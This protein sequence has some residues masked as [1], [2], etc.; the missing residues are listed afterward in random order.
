MIV[1]P[2]QNTEPV[3]E[4]KRAASIVKFVTTMQRESERETGP[5]R[6]RFELANK[7]FKG[8]QPWS[9]DR[10]NSQWMAQ[11]FVHEFSTIVRRCAAAAQDLVFQRPDFFS[12]V[13]LNE[14][15]M[16]GGELARISQ[17]AVNYYL[18]EARF[19]NLFYEYCLCGGINGV[20]I[21]K[22]TP[23][24]EK[25]YK[26]EYVVAKIQEQQEDSREQVRGIEPPAL[27]DLSDSPELTEAELKK[28]ADDIF[29]KTGSQ[30]P[31]LTPTEYLE[32]CVAI[33]LTNPPNW[34]WEPDCNDLQKT[35]Y[36]GEKFYKRFYELVPLFEAGVLDKTKKDELK[37]TVGRRDTAGS[38]QITTYEGQKSEQRDQIDAKNPYAPVVELVEYFGPWMDP[39]GDIVSE[40]GELQTH[41]HFIVGNGKVLLKDERIETYDQKSPYVVSVFSK[42]P[43]KAIGQGIADGAIDQN[44]LINQILGLMIDMLMLGIYGAKV[45]NMDAIVDE[46]QLEKGI[47]P[48]AIIEAYGRSADEVFSDIPFPINNLAP[49]VF[50]L[51]QYLTLTG[52]K[53]SGVDTQSTNPASRARISATEIQS[54]LERTSQS[55]LALGRELDANCIEPLV[56]KIFGLVLQYGLS[57]DNIELLAQ[58]GVITEDERELILGISEIER[59]NEIQKKYR[60]QVKGFRERLER[61]DFLEKL[62][63][64]LASLAQMSPIM[65]Q[66]TLNLDWRELIK[67]VVEAYGLDSD[68]L[69]PQN[70]PQDKA[71]EENNLLA[72][73]QL[74][75]IGEQD[76]DAYELPVHYDQLLRLPNNSTLRHVIGHMIKMMNA[77]QQPPPPPPEIARIPEIQELLGPPIDDQKQRVEGPN[78]LQ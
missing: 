47:Q 57:R 75:S 18:K 27:P 11:P 28:A 19:E 33:D 67:Q 2:E 21:F 66:G 71:R 58:K 54:N 7:M 30:R 23:K 72:N 62:N 1:S 63:N 41:R 8:E 56:H 51:I 74:I 42:S 68:K 65:P 20:G 12:L 26:A 17:K 55:V 34:F 43:F 78:T 37:N 53:G 39:T 60:V 4:D 15:D 29:G 16:G 48:G 6:Q 38:A 40:N 59:F 25:K 69:I 64:M 31:T 50:Q 73:D 36:A 44:I 70:S 77:G 45:A 49:Q 3:A 61:S 24:L 52:E 10:E 13:P 35:P 32:F 5:D 76:M 14:R 22:V 9:S 46:T